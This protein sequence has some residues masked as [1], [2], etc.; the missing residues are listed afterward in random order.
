MLKLLDYGKPNPFGETI[1]KQRNL[2]WPVSAYR[3]TLPRSSEDGDDLNPFERVIL[4]LLDAL[5]VMDARALAN[6]T[7]IPLDLVK[8][9]LLRLQDKELI[10][11]FNAIIEQERDIRRSEDEKAQ[12]YITALLFRELVTGKYLPFVHWLN[13]ANPLQKKEGEEDLFRS[14]RWDDAHKK[15]PATQRDVI[16]VLRATRRRSAVFGKDEAIPAVQQVTIVHQAE[17]HYLDCPIAIQ[18]SDGEFRIAD[19]FGNGFSLILERAFEQL[20]EQ[21]E[22]LADWLQKW[23]LSLSNPRI[24]HH[25]GKPKEQFESNA[26]WQR[27]PKL[28]ASLR[29]PQSASFHSIAQIYASIEWALF[30]ACYRRP[31]ENVIATLKFN[32]Q[33]EHPPLLSDAAKKIGLTP[34]QSGFRPIREGKLLDFQNGKAELETLLSIAILQAQSNESSHLSH[35]A[36]MYPEFI[37][38]LLSIKKR[39]D[40]KGHG[41]GSADAPDKELS[42]ASFMREIVHAL[43]PEIVFSGMPIVELDRDS[44]ADSLLD[45]RASIQSEFG[46]KTFNRLGANLQE[47]LIHAE[48]FFLSCKDGDD[49]LAFVRDLYAALQSVFEMSLASR[50]PPDADDALLIKLAGMRAAS[51]GFCSE[52]PESLR[53]VKA[54]A[55][56]QTLLG[57]G[58]SLGACVL[59]F[60]LMSDDDTLCSISDSQ[61][62]FVGDV[63]NVITRRGH[64][65]EPLPL[66]KADTAKLRKASYKTIKTLIEV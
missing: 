19:P 14:I 12:V 45:A 4:K 16:S 29:L 27:Y 47:R 24:Q 57:T 5:G 18:K 51:A 13:D 37:S 20:L 17:L 65:N 35:I 10:D 42:D 25:D 50:L 1:G 55:V 66:P 34:P 26:N 44:R 9:I 8:S 31:F 33:A 6:E 48:R 56:R 38:R 15:T 64:G 41:K 40:E 43:L 62:F 54:S 7:R 53:T 3:V 23:K 28:V 60:L 11:E 21:D 22:K 39:R 61:P 32:A 46:F 2:A 58:Q 59:A 36:S 63:T 49:A 30:Y 52:L